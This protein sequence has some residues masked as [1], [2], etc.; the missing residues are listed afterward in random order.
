MSYTWSILFYN[1]EGYFDT[2]SV[3]TV[4]SYLYLIGSLHNVYVFD[5]FF[6]SVVLSLVY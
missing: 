2:I 4:S 6:Y 1:K 5:W 3:S